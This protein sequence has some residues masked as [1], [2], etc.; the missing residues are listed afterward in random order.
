MRYRTILPALLLAAT[1]MLGLVACGSD[2]DP[3]DAVPGTAPDGTADS[4]TTAPATVPK[5]T[6]PPTEEEAVLAAVQCYWD[7]IV[8]ANDP[9]NPDHPGFERCMMGP[10]LEHSRRLTIEHREMNR[11]VSDPTGS[12]QRT[13]TLVTVE[14]D[15]AVVTEC[16]VDDAVVS[17]AAS[18]T[19]L[20]DRVISAEIRIDLERHDGAWR[21]SNGTVTADQEGPGQCVF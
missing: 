13:N 14:G 4:G 19:V 16:I 9:P 11:T 15:T 6:G 1:P 3:P 2:D 18:G 12:T 10:A 21:V 8:E 17:D 5:T 7:T 20:N